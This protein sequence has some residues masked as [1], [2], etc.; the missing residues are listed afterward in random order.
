MNRADSPANLLHAHLRD[1]F[2]RQADTA[3]RLR[4]STWQER[5]AKIRRLRDAVTARTDAWYAA[6]HADFHKPPGEVDLAEILPVCQE[7]NAAMA[8]LRHWVKPQRVWPT[9]LTLGTRS[10]VQCVPRGRCLILGPFNYPVN[11]TLGPL[12][13]AV[14]AGNTAIV[15]P[16]ELTPN[17]SR[18]IAEVVSEVFSEDEVAVIEGDAQLAKYLQALP[19]DHVFF[20]GS[21][22]V[23]KQ[24]MAAASQHLASVT[25]ELGG[26]SPA[27]VD[28]SADL[29][30]AARNI[31]WAKLANA[32]QTCIAPDHVYVHN[33]VKEQWVQH[34]REELESAFGSSLVQQKN[35][36]HLARIVN[37]QHAMRLLDLLMDAQTRGAQLL[38]GGV[39][40]PDAK[41]VQPT[42]LDCVSPE[43]RLSKEEI[44]GPLLP[45]IGFD[46]LSEVIA[47]IN[48]T[49][50][51]LALYLYSRNR[52][53]V[54]QVIRQTV[55]GGVCINHALIQF[56]HSRLP[57]GGINHSGM[58]SAHGHYGFKAFSHE[59]AVVRSQL[60][61]VTKLLA[62][63]EVHPMI[64]KVLIKARAFIR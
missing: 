24:V 22:A 39:I 28:A 57:F 29:Q 18:L 27:I 12:V 1:V 7:A 31:L 37:S 51:P 11:L 36:P 19:F 9:L 5:V 17:L 54:D 40:H 46:S 58:G 53:S 48:A 42:L 50:K 16:S 2:E 60:P 52:E 44:F 3:L 63:G 26:K 23:G 4:Q 10:E 32:G 14:A 8:Q 15:K 13:S 35:S 45:V 6:A 62:T 33:S 20:T 56:L 47:S 34:C 61:W 21:P 49:P 55:S 25:L 38:T 43:A 64:R 59:R 41:F 30:L